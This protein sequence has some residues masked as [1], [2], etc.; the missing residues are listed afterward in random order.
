[1]CAHPASGAILRRKPFAGL[2]MEDGGGLRSFSEVDG[3]NLGNYY[4]KRQFQRLFCILVGVELFRR[5]K[6]IK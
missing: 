5:L 6:S 4:Q 1:M 3:A 2:A